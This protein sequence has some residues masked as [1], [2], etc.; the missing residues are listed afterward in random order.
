MGEVYVETEIGGYQLFDGR[1]YP[2]TNHQRAMGSEQLLNVRDPDFGEIDPSVYAL[3][4]AIRT[5]A[6]AKPPQ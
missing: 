2:T 4:E 5:L 3:P 6:G 1:L